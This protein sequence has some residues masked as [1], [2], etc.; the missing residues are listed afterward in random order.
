LVPTVRTEVIIAVHIKVFPI[1]A[2][3]DFLRYRE[4]Y[5]RV[6]IECSA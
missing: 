1:M 4:Q 3:S 2:L 5:G 6:T